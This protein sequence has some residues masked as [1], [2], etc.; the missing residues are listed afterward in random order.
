MHLN[1]FL[2][3]DFNESEMIDPG[4]SP[5]IPNRGLGSWTLETTAI[6]QIHE[7]AKTFGAPIVSDPT[8]YESP[9]FGKA[10][11]LTMHAPNG[12]LIEVFQKL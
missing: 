7:K 10:K 3:L 1:H 9:I 2:F 8:V 4:V 6:E 12:F 5:R 11:V